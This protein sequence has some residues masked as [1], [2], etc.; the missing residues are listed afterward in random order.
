M[1][2]REA[3]ATFVAS[4][5]LHLRGEVRDVFFGWLEEKRPDLLPRYENLYANGAYLPSSEKQ[6]LGS[7]VKGWGKNQ[8][9]SSAGG[10]GGGGPARA[11]ARGGRSS[12]GVSADREAR[13]GGVH[14]GDRTRGQTSLF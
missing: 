8:R 2:A 13:T 10:A 9:R 1:A 12:Q 14:A 5:G 7:L 6:R 4:T 11:A 3:G